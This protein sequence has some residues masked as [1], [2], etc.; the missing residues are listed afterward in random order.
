MV[1][2][3]V[4]DGFE[5]DALRAGADLIFA[6]PVAAGALISGIEAVL[7]RGDGQ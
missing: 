2:D 7:R 6:K 3:R 4:D 1:T 5:G